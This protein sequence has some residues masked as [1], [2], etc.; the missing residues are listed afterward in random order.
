MSLF[1][2]DET[3]ELNKREGKHE[4]DGGTAHEYT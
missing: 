1:R 3:H 2:K 4:D